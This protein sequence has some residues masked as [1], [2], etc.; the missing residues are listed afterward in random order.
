MQVPRLGRLTSQNSMKDRTG[1][2]WSR[3]ENEATVADYFDMLAQELAGAPF[4]KADHNRNLQRLLDGR[5]KGSIEFKHQNISAVLID[6]GCQFISGYKP[7]PNYQ[8]PL[9]EVVESRLE[10]DID[11]RKLLATD[12][13]LSVAPPAIGDLLA[14][15]Q[16]PPAPTAATGHVAEAPERRTPSHPNYLEREA[17]NRDLGLQG[18]LLALEFERARLRRLGREDLA[19][20]IE[21]VAVTRGDGD[22]FD[23]LSFE[24]SGQERFVEVKTTKY[25]QYTPFFLTR[26]ELRVSQSVTERY[27]LYRLFDFRTG[28][29]LYALR[30][31]LAESCTLTPTTYL[32]GVR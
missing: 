14:I 12:A 16:S 15:Q 5:S 29:G 26:N 10:R 21:H 23:I 30:G 6:L 7:R 3:E 28:P 1:E 9:R 13:D 17:R 31:N 22:G 20:K 18:E 8:W 24:E 25:G 4:N 32:A 2:D 11:L 19:A 27:H